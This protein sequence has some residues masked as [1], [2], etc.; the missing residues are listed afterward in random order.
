MATTITATTLTVEINETISL[1]GVEYGNS[2]ATAFTSQGKVD[3]RIMQVASKGD[4]TDWTTVLAL[5]TADA[6]GT[7]VVNDF[8]YVRL[9]NLDDT[10]ALNLE[11]QATAGF[12]YFKVEAGENFLLMSPDIDFQASSTTAGFGDISAINGQS[13]DGTDNI[14]IEY[15][16]VTT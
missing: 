3:Q 5:S 1:N 8:A 4:G 10:H 6:K 14:D 15:L 12:F 11:I 9:T 13:D 2:L 16:I 7:V